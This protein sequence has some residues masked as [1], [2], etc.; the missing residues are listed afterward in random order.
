MTSLESIFNNFDEGLIILTL[1]GDPIYFYEGAFHIFQKIGVTLR[2][3]ENIYQVLPGE[4]A[5]R[6]T[7]IIAD[8]I[9]KKETVRSGSNQL[10]LDG[11][12][13]Y[14]DEIYVPSFDDN[15]ITH[16]NLLMSDNT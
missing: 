3:S 15:T 10:G 14:L 2:E 11:M 9:E 8:V 7:R 6:M 4:S 13:L 1:T 5:E 16:V 12:P